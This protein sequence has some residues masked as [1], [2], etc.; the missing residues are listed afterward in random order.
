LNNGEGLV[1]LARSE[2][3]NHDI[4]AVKTSFERALKRTTDVDYILVQE[5]IT[6]TVI[7][8]QR[9]CWTNAIYWGWGGEG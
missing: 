2:K 9:Y 3:I 8:H 5:V 1:T 6:E 4:M 7:K